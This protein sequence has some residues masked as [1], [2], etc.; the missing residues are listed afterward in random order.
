[1][2]PAYTALSAWDNL[3]LAWRKAA[4]GKRGLN[5][6]STF[7]HGLADNLLALQTALREQT[8]RPGPYVNFFIHEPKQ[9]KISAAP[10]RD[11]VVYH[12]LCNVLEPRFERL[13]IADSY[14][15]RRGKGTH[16]AVARVQHF[17]QRHR[18]AL[19]CDVVQHF[20]AIDH[21]IL[22]E[23]LARVTPE[24][25]VM[26]LIDVILASG[27]GVLHEQYRMIWFPGDDLLAACRPRGLPIGN[28]TSQF[29]S[30]CYLHAFDQFVT[31][32]LRCTAY[33]R[34]VDDFVL[35]SNSKAE[36][37]AWKRALIQRLAQ[38]R[39]VIHETAAQVVPVEH[40]IPWLGFVV[41]PTHRRVKARKVVQASRRLTSRLAEYQRGD[42]SRDDFDASVKGWVNHVRYAD[43]WG[44][45]RH[46]LGRLQVHLG[47][48]K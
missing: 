9:R 21:L 29:W 6:A 18:Y 45:R 39:L 22:R 2:T 14:A 28:L 43:A 12:A 44:L 41:Y 17:A 33:V 8:Y 19:R 47:V 37:W 32:E 42:I 27:A 10:F 38:L 3:L 36:L 25:D 16:R 40:G 26:N 24:T 13:F 48:K 15:N 35:F 1:M 7:E 31:R 23:T 30:N 34:Y 5:A 20:A 11:R 4:R 46:V